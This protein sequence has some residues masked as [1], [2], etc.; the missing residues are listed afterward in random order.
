[1]C[2]FLRMLSLP[3]LENSPCNSN[4]V[5]VSVS[6]I[7]LYILNSNLTANKKLEQ[8]GHES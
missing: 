5:I 6:N 7:I 1:M 4:I 3:A 2:A 8:D